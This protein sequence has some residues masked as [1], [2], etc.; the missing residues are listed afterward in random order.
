MEKTPQPGERCI[1]MFTHDF[2][3]FTTVREEKKSISFQAGKAFENCI[4]QEAFHDPYTG[5]AKYAI[6]I[7]LKQ[8]AWTVHVIQK[9]VRFLPGNTA[10][11]HEKNTL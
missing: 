11:I 8:Q 6:Q 7:P 1:V 3:Q 10:S 5:Q 4:F 9:I 2:T